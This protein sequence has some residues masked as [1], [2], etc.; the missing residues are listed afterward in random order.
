MN[1]QINKLLSSTLVLSIN[2]FTAL[3]A[4][5]DPDQM[6]QLETT[7]PGERLTFLPGP[8]SFFISTFPTNA[9]L[10]GVIDETDGNY[11]IDM[12]SE[13]DE[14]GNHRKISVPGS[15]DPVFSPDGKLMSVSSGVFSFY[16]VA[17]IQKLFDGG[18][19]D[20]SNVSPVISDEAMQGAYQSIGMPKG[21]KTTML[22]D[23]AQQAVYRAIIET[24]DDGASNLTVRDYTVK[25]SA[26]GKYLE[27]TLSEAQSLCPDYKLKTPKISKSGKY[28]AAYSIDEKET[29]IFEIDLTRDDNNQQI[30]SCK[31]VPGIDFGM[32]TGKVDFNFDDSLIAYHITRYETDIEVEPDWPITISA[33]ER[34]D[35]YVAKIEDQ[36]L[37]SISRITPPSGYGEGGWYPSFAQNDQLV[38]M[39]KLVATNESSHGLVRVNPHTMEY[40]PYAFSPRSLD[41]DAK[42][43]AHALHAIANIAKQS[44][45]WQ[46]NIDSLLVDILTLTPKGCREMVTNYWVDPGSSELLLSLTQGNKQRLELDV[47]QKVTQQDTLA[48]CDKLTRTGKIGPIIIPEPDATSGAQ[49]IAGCNYCHYRDGGNAQGVRRINFESPSSLTLED[50]NQS[51]HMIDYSPMPALFT[52]AEQQSRE[53]GLTMPQRDQLVGD[54]KKLAVCYLMQQRAIKYPL[55]SRLPNYCGIVEFTPDY[56]LQANLALIDEGS[57]ESKLDV[58]AGN[59]IVERNFSIKIVIRHSY[60]SDLKVT[61]I[62]PQGTKVVLYN[63]RDSDSG[64]YLQ[65]VYPTLLTPEEPLDAMIGEGLSGQWKLAIEDSFAG[66]TGELIY[67]AISN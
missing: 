6:C 3:M 21:Y 35:V 30:H 24:L 67:W 61:L 22:P 5:A 52:N 11:I 34:R 29:K 55:A 36:T 42:R 2:A 43:Q 13:P 14:N 17:D 26:E 20:A 58:A 63:Q 19:T 38:Y 48:M 46:E 51:L 4:S 37:Q 66:D 47:L 62:S 18:A 25:Y 39:T 53:E 65:G 49:V 45:N 40:L 7:R 27:H 8:A 9:N 60:I 44:C 23:G 31:E 15:Y 1:I 59:T 32:Q 64:G 12:G 10:V 54:R 41:D 28:L 33:N 50:F 56:E 16:E 57:V